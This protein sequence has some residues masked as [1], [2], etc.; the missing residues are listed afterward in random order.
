MS[1]T[2]RTDKMFDIWTVSPDA[3]EF[4]RALEKEINHLQKYT[5]DLRKKLTA[6]EAQVAGIQRNLVMYLLPMYRTDPA[7][8]AKLCDEVLDRSGRLLGQVRDAAKESGNAS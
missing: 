6:A 3:L 7:G 5:D 4:T 1:D 2:P 8:I